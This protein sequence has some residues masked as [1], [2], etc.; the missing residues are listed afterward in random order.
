MREA[1]YRRVCPNVRLSHFFTNLLSIRLWRHHVSLLASISLAGLVWILKLWNDIERPIFHLNI[2]KY[3]Y[4][5]WRKFWI[6]L[7]WDDFEWLFSTLIFFNV[8]GMAEENFEFWSCENG[9]ERQI[10]TLNFRNIFTMAEKK[11]EFWSSEMAWNDLFH[12]G[13]LGPW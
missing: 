1:S 3:L 11:F 13:Q 6:L 2:S 9:L 10:C 7:L 4:H 8:S 12:L 5:G